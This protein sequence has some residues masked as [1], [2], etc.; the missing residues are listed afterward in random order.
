[1]SG[2]LPTTRAPAQVS[3]SSVSP[4]FIS[5]SHSLKEQVRRRGAGVQRWKLQF[6][7]GTMERD[8]YM[9]LWAFLNS[10]RG[11]YGSFTAALPA[12]ITPRGAL[13]GTP[14]VMGAV[15]AGA[16]S[17]AID[18]CSN[19]ITGWGKSGDFFKFNGHSKVYQLT[20][21]VDTDG[22]GQ[23]TLAFMPALAVDVA[24]NDPVTFSDVP[25]TLRLLGDE[26]GLDLQPPTQGTLDFAAIE[27]Y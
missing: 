12:N 6:S 21:D 27:R 3:V 2:A 14:L 4:T 20:A 15:S 10:Q 24:D 18:G 1:M 11:R 9:A 25:F 7:Y 22:S 26:S 23:A 17:V 19:G 5:T 13:G 16:S 8:E